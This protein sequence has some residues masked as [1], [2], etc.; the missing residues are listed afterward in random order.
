MIDLVAVGWL[1]LD[2]IV[3]PDRTYDQDVLGGGALYA[4]IGAQI[5]NDR[6][7]IHSVTGRPYIEAVQSALQA[8]GLDASGVACIDG[9]GLQLWILH[10]SNADKQ[11]IPKLSSSTAAEMDAGRGPLPES[12]RQSARGYH[13]APQGSASTLAT[14]RALTALPRRPVLTLDVLADAYVDP[15]GYRDLSFLK[16][17]TAFLPSDAEIERLWAPADLESWVVEQARQAN[18]HVAAKLGDQGS[19]VCEGRGGMLHCVPIYPADVL[20][21]TGA[22][23]SYCGGFLAGLVAGR[24]VAECAAMGTV[25]ASFVVEARGALATRRPAAEER[26]TRLRDVMSRIRREEAR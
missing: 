21:T 20:D 4:A 17:V 11:Q 24:P 26:D 14:I 22:G 23:D 13:I 1:T 25:S 18:C 19:I 7:G 10:E 8:H 5:W 9:N 16:G 12:Y 2:D 3:L 15:A 6:V